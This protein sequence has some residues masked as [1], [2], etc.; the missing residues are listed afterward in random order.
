M[1]TRVFSAILFAAFALIMLLLGGHFVPAAI[2]LFSII[3][4]HEFYEAFKEKGVQPIQSI[5]GLY[6]LY[7]VPFFFEDKFC[8]KPLN[9]TSASI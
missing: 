8:I 7:I 9:V 5:G 2:L 1:K 6:L 4:L 3:G